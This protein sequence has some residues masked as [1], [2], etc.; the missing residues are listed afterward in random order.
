MNNSMGLKV[1]FS[2]VM[3]V[4]INRHINKQKNK[5]KKIIHT[6]THTKKKYT[7]NP[8]FKNHK[9]TCTRAYCSEYMY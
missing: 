7:A 1:I 3:L 9:S 5:K 4:T 6:H 8:E 2:K